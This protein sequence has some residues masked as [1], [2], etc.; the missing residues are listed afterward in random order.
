[1]LS[2]LIQK[3]KYSE[4]WYFWTKHNLLHLTWNVWIVKPDAVLEPEFEVLWADEHLRGGVS[5]LL[6]QLIHL[7]LGDY[8]DK[9]LRQRQPPSQR[10]KRETKTGQRQRQESRQRH[11][12]GGVSGLHKQLNHPLLMDDCILLWLYYIVIVLYWW[13]IVFYCDY[14]SSSC[15]RCW[16]LDAVESSV[17]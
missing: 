7:L 17:V 14:V 11:L 8:T 1:M 4:N 6:K 13:M 15:Y 3:I 9:T 10:Q 5:G 16:I 2:K 12:G